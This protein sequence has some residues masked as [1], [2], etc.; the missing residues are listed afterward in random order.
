MALKP[1]R[2]EHLTDL[3]FFMNVTAERG[4]VVTYKTGGSGVAM[5]DDAAVVEVPTGGV[6]GTIPAGLLLNDV[7]NLDLTRTHLNE[8]QDEVQ[9]GSKVLL[10]KN[11]FVVTDQVSGSP[12]VGQAAYY[13]SSGQLTATNP[14]A[15]STQPA[16]AINAHENKVGTFL[17]SKD[18]DGYAKVAI[19]IV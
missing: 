2:H 17:S 13:D 11:G 14:L 1:D 16:G 7:V 8:H 19:N 9:I 18:A 6:S 10:L 4:L 15:A 5:D 12:T 3:S